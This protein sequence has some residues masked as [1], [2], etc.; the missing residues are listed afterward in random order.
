MVE[1]NLE[2]IN[3]Y[4]C[5]WNIDGDIDFWIQDRWMTTGRLMTRWATKDGQ[6]GR[7]GVLTVQR[8][9]FRA[10]WIWKYKTE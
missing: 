9:H 5:L 2:R 8:G 10:V 1:Q 4:S 6:W 7:R 3:L